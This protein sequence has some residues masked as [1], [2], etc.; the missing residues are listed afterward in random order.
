MPF[1]SEK[2]KKLAELNFCE[3]CYPKYLE[4]IH[5]TIE[6]LL[7]EPISDW[8]D[9]EQNINRLWIKAKGFYKI[10]SGIFSPCQNAFE[11]AYNET[12]YNK[13]KFLKDNGV[14]K[15]YT[16]EFLNKVRKRRNNVHPPNKF[17]E[18]DYFLFQEARRMTDA[19]LPII[20]HD[21]NY[22]PWKS[23]LA[24]IEKNA[25]QLL[26]KTKLL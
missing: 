23:H 26:E 20:I 15:E 19:M 14:I 18:Q 13:L 8:R 4:L 12:A 9:V 21:L 16:Y 25:K 7:S 24:N 17:S 10:N 11:K 1:P 22:A 5:P 2:L 6:Y 3:D